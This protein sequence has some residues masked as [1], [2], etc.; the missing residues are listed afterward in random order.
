MLPVLAAGHT[1][2][3]RRRSLPVH[4]DGL[5]HRLLGHTADRVRGARAA[6][7]DLRLGRAHAEPGAHADAVRLAS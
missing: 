2:G 4:P 6:R 1:H 7:L 5:E 3:L